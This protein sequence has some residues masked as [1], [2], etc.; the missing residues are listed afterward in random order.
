MKTIRD[1][2]QRCCPLEVTIT[3][4]LLV[5]LEE[6]IR[7]FSNAKEERADGLENENICI[8]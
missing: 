4:I 7:V 5:D 6:N 1:E 3:F 8:K 2:R